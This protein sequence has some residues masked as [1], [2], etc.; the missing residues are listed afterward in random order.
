MANPPLWFV[1]A[2]EGGKSAS[3]FR[4]TNS[5][6]IGWDK[7]GPISPDTPD[8]EIDER[9]ARA[10]PDNKENARNVYANQVRRFLREIRIGDG[11]ATYD[12]LASALQVSAP[13][14][15]DIRAGRRCPHQRHWLTLSRL[16]QS[17]KPTESWANG[18]PGRRSDRTSEQDD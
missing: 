14:A 9:F 10:Y 5:V 3:D 15:V 4:S 2:G 13:Y 8:E 7:V 11:V 6:G 1:R 12:P 17:V 18:P 16:V